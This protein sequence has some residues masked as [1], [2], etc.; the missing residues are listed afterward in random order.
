MAKINNKHLRRSISH[1]N[2]IKLY[3]VMRTN[4]ELSFVFELCNESLFDYYSKIK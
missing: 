4:D 3:E 2:L 1:P